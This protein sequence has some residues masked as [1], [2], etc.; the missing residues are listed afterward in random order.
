MMDFCI[1]SQSNLISPYKGTYSVTAFVLFSALF[2]ASCTSAPKKSVVTVPAIESNIIDPKVDMT[3]TAEETIALA[4]DA[5]PTEAK[6]FLIK[7]TQLYLEQEYNS[8]ALWLADKLLSLE[9]SEQERY[10]LSLIKAQALQNLGYSELALESLT[11]IEETYPQLYLTELFYQTSVTV[12]LS[13]DKE[14]LALNAN[15]YADELNFKNYNIADLTDITEL[16]DDERTLL[17]EKITQFWQ[18]I[19]RLPSWKLNSLKSYNAPQV[20]GWVALLSKIKTDPPASLEL[21][22]NL[23]QWS[24]KYPNHPAILIIPTLEQSHEVVSSQPRLP[25]L[26]DKEQTSSKMVEETPKKSTT[27]INHA[28]NNNKNDFTNDVNDTSKIEKAF[29]ANQQL[30][31]DTS[32]PLV[33]TTSNKFNNIAVLL[34]LSGSQSVAGNTIQQGILTAYHNNS[35][36]KLHFYDTSSLDWAM[37]NERFIKDEIDFTIGPILKSNVQ[38]LQLLTGNDLPGLLLNVPSKEKLKTNQYA[39]SM[40][41]E[42]EAKQSAWVLSEQEYVNPIVLS[43]DDTVSRR[44]A[45]AFSKMWT[46]R[47]GI[48]VKIHYFSQG[49]AMQDSL[50]KGFDVNAS[51]NRIK[52]IERL[53]SSPVKS[54][55]RNRRDVDMIY[56]VGTTAQTKLVKPFIDV[57]TSRFSK[58]IPV[59][60]S[61]RSHDG[62]D[63][64]STNNDLNGLVFTEAPLLLPA[65]QQDKKLSALNKQL[66]PNRNGRLSRLYAMGFDSYNLIDLISSMV[67]APYL[68]YD[69][70]TGTLRLNDNVLSRTLLWGQYQRNGVAAITPN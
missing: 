27:I 40:L 9:V 57:N 29:E 21:H 28:A 54:E 45:K 33:P 5:N 17:L 44:I 26:I 53:N 39:F 60:A 24:A 25:T 43:H 8:K 41:P 42:E 12:Y 15:L 58:Q 36:K 35:S 64:N 70:Q 4:S 63:D 61:S 6:K 69:G 34:P 38:K 56:L 66:Y 62:D 11:N 7:A 3:I 13:L 52:Q 55:K 31:A 16:T 47:T 51:E 68:R 23:I 14:I 22:N 19:E 32:N 65:K 37:L 49:K 50:Q 30:L 1:L 59:F 67:D 10:D 46:K 48:A 2:L 20:N 18:Q